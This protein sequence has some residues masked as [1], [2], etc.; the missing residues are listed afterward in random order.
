LICRNEANGWASTVERSLHRQLKEHYRSAVG[1]RTEVVLGEFRVDA[2]APDGRLIEI[3]SSP[4]GLLKHKLARLLPSWEIHVVKPVVVSRR[5]IRRERADGMDLSARRSPRRGEML[6]VFDELVGL[7]HLF[8][9]ANLRIDIVAVE[10]DEIRV[11]R[12]RRPGYLVADR[13]LRQVVE[14][15]QLGVAEDLWSLLPTDLASRFTT[16]DLAA[17]IGRGVDFARRVAY[18]LRQS[19]AAEP[20]GKIGNRRVYQRSSPGTQN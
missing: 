10:V 17:R 5:L 18:C 1:G 14:T 3:Q 4:L 11:A 7:V 19:G 13:I 2:Q 12:G 15:I 8:P 6:D 9:H 16:Q 20:V